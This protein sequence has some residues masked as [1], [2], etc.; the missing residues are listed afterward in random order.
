MRCACD[1]VRATENKTAQDNAQ[2]FPHALPP[3]TAF[4][5]D[6]RRGAVSTFMNRLCVDS[7]E[8]YSRE[9]SVLDTAAVEHG[10]QT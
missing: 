6:T 1:E 8:R 9:L 3:P 4:W 7:C 10:I 5:L 2:N